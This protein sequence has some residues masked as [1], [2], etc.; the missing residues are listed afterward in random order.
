MMNDRAVEVVGV[1][2]DTKFD[3]LRAAV[4]PTAYVPFRQKGQYAMTFVLR[5]EA[6][7]KALLPALRRAVAQVD[8]NVPLYRVRTQVQQIAEATRRERL[9]ASLL[10][11]FSLVAL[12]LAGV[13]VHG[14]LAYQVARRTPEIGLRAALGARARDA[15]R[16]VIAEVLAPVGVGIGVGLAS[17]LL[18]GR[19]IDSMLFGVTPGD[20]VVLLVAAGFLLAGALV[21]A[22]A[23]ARRAARIAPM[24]ALRQE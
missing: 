12:V 22:W 21:A 4:R 9:L 19:L 13:G 17:A 5:S 6:A 14:T 1:A 7:P 20:P 18:A 23:P 10:S 8:P 15:A 3:S 16:L 2:G 24:D 11:G